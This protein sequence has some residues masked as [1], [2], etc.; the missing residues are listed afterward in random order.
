MPST[1]FMPALSSTMT[2]GRLVR[3]FVH[4]GEMVGSGDVLAEIGVSDSEIERLAEAG[5]LVLPDRS[6]SEAAD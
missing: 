2:E 3:W 5:H 4:E 1:V 6:A